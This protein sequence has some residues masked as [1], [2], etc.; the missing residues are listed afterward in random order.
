MYRTPSSQM[1]RQPS[2]PSTGRRVILFGR[3]PAPG[4]T[5]T[6][7]IP[8]LGPV[9][10][11][12]LQRRLTEKTLFTLLQSGRPA[13]SVT[14]CHTGAEMAKIRRWLG[15]TG[16]R[17]QAQSGN[18]LGARMHQALTNELNQGA[19]KAI[20]VGTDIPDLTAGHIEAAFEALDLHDLVLGP[21][22]D[23]GYWLIGLKRPVDVFRNI[24]WGGPAVLSRTLAAAE[25]LGLSSTRL[26]PLN[27]IDTSEDFRRWRQKGGFSPPYL[28]VIVPTLNE[29][30]SIEGV[31]D[32]IRTRDSEIIVADGGSHD[33]TA[34]LARSAGAKVITAAPGRAVQQNAAARAASGRVLLF[35]HA[36]TFL[37]ANYA[38]QIFETLMDPQ[39]AAGAFRFR[40]DYHCRRMRLIEQTVQIRS[41][42]FQL[43]YGDQALF[44][45]ATVFEKAG[46]FPDVPI[47]ED[48][49]LVR[50]LAR[51]GRIALTRGAAVT[52]GRRWRLNGVGHTTLIN[53]IIAAGCL[54]GI[55]PARL[56][57][58]YGRGRHVDDGRF[59]SNIE[60]CSEKDSIEIQ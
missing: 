30:S 46:G 38:H 47:A 44:M 23:G 3:Y 19:E 50:R 39:V 36:D 22:R 6:R 15:H 48:L 57:P 34:R 45:P 12:D 60:G 11:A 35:L 52:S 37:P 41:A 18:D 32:R 1:N 21:S 7:L 43:P 16:I 10:A 26:A 9:G 14:F 53:A 2:I 25:R 17:F 8:E 13:S 58:L 27:D 40:T 4:G 51:M 29:A 24:P 31:I 33:R 55:D 54:L 20:L 28:T 56:A 49:F 42:L 5:K 59:H